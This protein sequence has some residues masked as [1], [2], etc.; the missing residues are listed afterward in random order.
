MVARVANQLPGFAGQGEMAHQPGGDGT[1][2]QDLA[3]APTTGPSR[4]G[5]HNIIQRFQSDGRTRLIW[6]AAARLSTAGQGGGERERRNRRSDE[7]IHTRQLTMAVLFMPLF[8]HITAPL[9]L[10]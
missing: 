4:L 9:V 6:F 7:R 10:I 5:P 8:W 2:F 3:G 1:G